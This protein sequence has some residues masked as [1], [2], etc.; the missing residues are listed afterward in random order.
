MALQH[1]YRPNT[2]EEYEGNDT[3]KKAVKAWFKKKD[4]NR[5][6][7]ITGDSGCGKTTLG[8]II[9][10]M[11]GAYNPTAKGVQMNYHEH[12]AADDR[13][14]GFVRDIKKSMWNSPIGAPH[15]VY[16]LDECHSMTAVAQEAFLKTLEDV[17]AH[18]IFIL[19]TTNP[20]KLK[21]TLKRRCANFKV[22]PMKGPAIRKYLSEVCQAEEKK[23]PNKILK[24]ISDVSLGS[25][26]VSVGLLDAVIDL[27]AEDMEDVVNQTEAART[28]AFELC[29]AFIKSG[30][31]GPSWAKI[32]AIFTDIENEDPVGIRMMVLNTFKKRLL[33]KY[34]KR[35]AI[36]YTAFYEADVFG[37]G[38]HAIFMACL[39][40]ST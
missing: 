39:A 25:L 9:A 28:K 29:M 20:E 15:K 22:S 12:D 31:K 38:M 40:A 4:R 32:S 37:N 7:L 24:Y 2:L 11:V 34:D 36:L 10:T 21:I 14:V 27:D 33:K 1:S 8:R 13:G 5:A 26:G 17:P 30:P 35:E 19:A 6:I 18:V 23:V 3:T 16:L